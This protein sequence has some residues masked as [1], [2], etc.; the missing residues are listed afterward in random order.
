MS[1]GYFEEKD[2]RTKKAPEH[3]R[4][5]KRKVAKHISDA[6]VVPAVKTT[7]DL[8][9]T[10]ND[11]IARRILEGGWD[12]EHFS[13]KK[14]HLTSLEQYAEVLA[15]KRHY[16]SIIKVAAIPHRLLKP[17]PQYKGELTT[18]EL[19]AKF[20][21]IVPYNFILTTALSKEHFIGRRSVPNMADMINMDSPDFIIRDDKKSTPLFL[22]E[23]H[24]DQYLQALKASDIE[25]MFYIEKTGSILGVPDNTK[26]YMA[27]YIPSPFRDP[28]NISSIYRRWNPYAAEVIE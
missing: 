22:K 20:S 23:W 6:E 12:P 7:V 1:Q 24:L 11:D 17:N 2:V 4:V 19:I 5:A 16:K 14:L 9:F 10:A 21:D 13:E 26:V 27:R 15:Q 18:E 8:Y 25:K 28:E 3:Q